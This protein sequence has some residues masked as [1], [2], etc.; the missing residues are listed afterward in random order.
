MPNR[1]G[2]NQPE[3]NRRGYV[4]LAVI[5]FLAMAA[6]LASIAVMNARTSVT[7][8]SAQITRAQMDASLHGAIARA[9]YLLDD[10]E[11]AGAWGQ[12]MQIRMPGAD[13]ELRMQDVRGLVDI[14]AA[15]A[16]LL[17]QLIE[18]VLPATTDAPDPEA[19]ADAIV[20][21][22]DADDE[23]LP[24][25]AEK[26]QY[27][28]AGLP[29]PGNRPF[30]DTAELGRV[31]GFT[32][33]IVRD[34]LPLI[35]VHSGL[36]KP[37]AILAPD[38]VLA[39]LDLPPDALRAIAQAREDDQRPQIDDYLPR[40]DKDKDAKDD[41]KSGDRPQ[42]MRWAHVIVRL[43]L[44]DGA[45]RAEQMLLH[46]PASGQNPALYGRQVID[47][48]AL[49]AQFTSVEKKWVQVRQ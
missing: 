25:G 30:A 16:E 35:T 23:V 9:M 48:S 6:A 49:G 43:S 32:P 19:L 47:Y 5:A 36:D 1:Y 24:R 15:S 39:L 13:V 41:T 40:D 14:N 27:S 22:R 42:S 10:P 18:T 44:P 34:L 33:D 29:P 11:S 8:M 2:P 12:E 3:H 20:D 31:Y 45:K 17:T 37:E 21:W 28:A 38:K 4:L 46:I 7:D 26:R